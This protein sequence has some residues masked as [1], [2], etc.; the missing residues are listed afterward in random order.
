MKKLMLAVMIALPALPAP[1]FAQAITNDRVLVI[2][3]KD[4]CP[5]NTIC[6]IAPE[7]ERYRIPKALR[8]TG[9]IAPQ[10]QSWAQRA[11]QVD[12]VGRTGPGS[13]SPSGP[14][15]W[16]GCWQQQMRAARADRANSAQENA[17]EL[18]K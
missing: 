1:A 8:N 5:A 2:F 3:G 15:G 4:V 18:P 7:N 13:C 17:A 14:G 10:N 6:V 16:T 9:P 11:Q 12:S